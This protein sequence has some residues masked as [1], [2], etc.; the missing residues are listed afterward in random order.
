MLGQ[1]QAAYR[2]VVDAVLPSVVEIDTG[3]G[4]GSGVVMDAGGSIVTNAHVVAGA[5]S[6]TVKTPSGQSYSATLVGTYPN[7]D[8]AVIKVSAGSGDGG[9]GLKPATFGD[10]SQLHIGDIVVAIG[11]PLGLIDSVSEGIVSGT[12]RTQDEGNG[13]TLS[14]LIQTTAAISPGSS[15]GALVD[16]NGHVIGLTTLGVTSG[17][18]GGTAG[19]IGFA[20]SSNQVV[21][22][23]KQPPSSNSSTPSSGAAG[24]AYLGVSV[25][26]DGNGA[27]VIAAVEPGGPAESAGVPNG[28][29][30]TSIDGQSV[31]SP[32]ALS[33]IL[34]THKP[35]DSIAL[36]VR[37]RTGGARTYRVT[38]GVHP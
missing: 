7:N 3:S 35:G 18:R 26:A 23:T 34:G 25:A 29:T 2:A 33:R 14:D 20:I 37:L 13:V 36:T 15:G 9:S 4:E 1:L 12:G 21:S 16:I 22:V 28:A 5:S 19:G 38:L 32:S 8:L 24:S 10:S 27:A 17:G 6:L 30:I 11:S 31:S